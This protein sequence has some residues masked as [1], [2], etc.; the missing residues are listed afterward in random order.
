MVRRISL[1]FIIIIFVFLFSLDVSAEI[2]SISEIT[3]EINLVLPIDDGREF[4]YLYAYKEKLT[5][6]KE[7][8]DS[9]ISDLLISDYKAEYSFGL[10]SDVNLNI[11]LSVKDKHLDYIEYYC[12]QEL[13]I[14]IIDDI[15][16]KNCDLSCYD[17]FLVLDIN[18]VSYKYD[19]SIKEESQINILN[20]FINN[21]GFHYINGLKIII[22][23]LS[24]IYHRGSNPTDMEL[25][26]MVRK[27]GFYL[28]TYGYGDTI[29]YKNAEDGE[30][31]FYVYNLMHNGDL[32]KSI[33]DIVI[34]DENSLK[35]LEANI[36]YKTFLNSRKYIEKYVIGTNKY[37]NTNEYII[38]TDYFSNYNK[39]GKYNVN[40]KYVYDYT[41]IEASGVINVIDD[42]KPYFIGDDI[43]Y[44]KLSNIDGS[45]EDI[46]SKIKAYDE[47]DED[48]S[49]LIEYSDLDN[50]KDNYG[51]VG[52]YRF[53]LSVSDNSGNNIEK[54]ITYVLE[55]D[56]SV[57]I[58]ENNKEESNSNDIDNIDAIDKSDIVEESDEID[59][60]DND[61]KIE[62]KEE[63]IIEVINISNKEKLSIDDIKRK[64]IFNGY[65]DS[66]FNG[67]IISDYF[68]SDGSV[69]EYQV[70]V[71]DSGSINY[72][73]INVFEDSVDIKENSI[74]IGLIISISAIS[75]VIVIVLFI[76]IRRKIKLNK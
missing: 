32:Y 58:D 54:E 52:S 71:I 49:N 24:N 17:E 72:Y 33:Y 53:L 60:I 19:V 20:R 23:N 51:K 26:R 45:I 38:N 3:D 10:S 43:I 9:G 70:S 11:V 5:D 12:N 39:V 36:S 69:G 67:E 75:L 22:S 35:C 14:R 29:Y 31:I 37:F 8:Y 40:L 59:D 68:D 41:V 7:R 63:A 1:L 27:D 55:D 64:L 50:Y 73:L 57:V 61:N 56:I 62:K 28:E 34:Y 25:M 46:I 18:N 4:N 16:I 48:I 65:I 2:E 47:I 30:Y 21:V 13:F 42:I 6:I 74:N 15:Y 76:I 66:D 44:G